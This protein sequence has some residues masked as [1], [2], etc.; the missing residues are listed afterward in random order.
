MRTTPRLRA[1]L[2]AM[3]VGVAALAV[4]AIGASAHTTPKVP[5][6]VIPAT[7]PAGYVEVS[8]LLHAP[9]GQQTIAAVTCP[10]GTVA[11]GGGVASYSPYG[12]AGTYPLAGGAGWVAVVNYPNSVVYNPFGIYA[13]CA[14]KP[15][16]Y[17]IV[18]AAGV[19][20]SPGG[21]RGDA[22]FC[23]TGAKVLGGGASIDSVWPTVALQSSYPYQSS[24]NYA[25][26]ISVANASTSGVSEHAWA[27]CGKKV[28]GWKLVVGTGVNVNAGNQGGAD[29][30]CPG[31]SVV[32]GGGATSSSGNA[33]ATL[34]LSAPY[35]SLHGWQG[36]GF[37]GS[38]VAE[39]ITPYAIC[40]GT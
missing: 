36:N 19:V 20:V 15:A 22:A 34:Y 11:L 23:P 8:T 38:P 32:L 17:K 26:G 4:P 40:A 2:V 28:K 13:L 3:L 25:W 7:A 18:E 16:G 5:A 27:I 6:R 39:Q 24:S 21:S 9:G 31:T 10:M 1:G 12:L 30:T 29:V 37:N 33:G 35:T 14:K